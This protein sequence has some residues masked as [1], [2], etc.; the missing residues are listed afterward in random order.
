MTSDH[1]RFLDQ[2]L[3]SGGR[4]NNVRE[5]R[6]Q[7]GVGSWCGGDEPEPTVGLETLGMVESVDS[8][9]GGQTVLDDLSKP[10]SRERYEAQRER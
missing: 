9:T 5:S 2:T 7:I 1:P 10:V 6:T 4:W 8:E 3:D